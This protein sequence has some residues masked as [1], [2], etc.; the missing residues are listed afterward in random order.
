MKI[1]YWF[2]TVLGEAHIPNAEK[3]HQ[4][5]LPHIHKIKGKKDECFNYYQVH[6]DK[7]FNNINKFV[8]TQVNEFSKQH[9]FGP[10]KVKDSW[11]NDYKKYN[12]NTSH[13]HPG[14]VFTAVYYLVGYIE[15]T[16][17]VIHS[18]I[19]PDMMNPSDTT[20]ND[21]L[22]NINTLTSDDIIIKPST[23]YVCIFRSF[24]SHEVPLK[25][26]DHRRISLSYTFIRDVF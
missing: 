26:T 8:L 23:G 21:P 10:M 22:K 16:S 6:K 3:E 17:L 12:V 5:L 11:F 2:P 4:R 25:I 24:L 15:D 14:S 19:P 20:S 9:R 18:P 7:K 13:A 1:S